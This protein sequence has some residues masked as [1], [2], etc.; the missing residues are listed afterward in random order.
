MNPDDD[1]PILAQQEALLH[2]PAFDPAAAWQLGSLL[3]DAL[4]TR[5][6]GGTVEIEFDHQLLFACTTP[7]AKPN[8]ADWIRRKRNSVRRLGRCTYAIGRELARENAT[9]DSAHHLSE[10]DFAAHGG[11]F[12]IRLIANPQTIAGTIVLSGL[13]QRDDH[14]LVVTAIAQ[15][16]GVA[17]PQLA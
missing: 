7:G 17:I 2:F 3:H 1:L 12:P 4:V 9:L 15:F 5:N 6:A 14:N 16:L 10:T 8:Q 11:G 13:P